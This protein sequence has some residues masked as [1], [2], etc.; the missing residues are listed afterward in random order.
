MSDGVTA[1]DPEVIDV[2]DDAESHTAG[3]EG[4]ELTD[5]VFVLAAQIDAINAIEDDDTRL[6]AAK[7]WA[8]ALNGG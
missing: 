2:T 3:D 5:E 7:A 4:I 1:P 8:E 6:A